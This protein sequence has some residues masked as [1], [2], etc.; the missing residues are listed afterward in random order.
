LHAWFTTG[1]AT[2]ASG[3]RLLG[4]AKGDAMQSFSVRATWKLFEVCIVRC[5]FTPDRRKSTGVSGYC[6]GDPSDRAAPPLAAVG[7]TCCDLDLVARPAPLVVVEAQ[8]A[9]IE[10]EQHADAVAR[11]EPALLVTVGH[12]APEGGSPTDAVNAA[13]AATAEVEA[14]PR[15]EQDATV[16]PGGCCLFGPVLLTGL[17]YTCGLPHTLNIWFCHS[18]PELHIRKGKGAIGNATNHHLL[19]TT[20]RK[21]LANVC[22]IGLVDWGK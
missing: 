22:L 10:V 5:G 20:S 4:Q 21:G 7:A 11:R 3:H 15:A 12:A 19:F 13:A 18:P 6:W 16:S 8:T 9:G 17:Y 1:P 2:S 14:G